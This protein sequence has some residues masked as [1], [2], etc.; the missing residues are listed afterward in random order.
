MCIDLQCRE[1]PASCRLSQS[2]PID[3]HDLMTAWTKDTFKQ[4]RPVGWTI[5]VLEDTLVN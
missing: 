2:V 4:R 1:A 5:R 3:L